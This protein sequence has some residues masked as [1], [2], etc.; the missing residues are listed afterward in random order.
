MLARQTANAFSKLRSNARFCP[1]VWT[2]MSSS[3]A[4]V[5]PIESNGSKR[6]HEGGYRF[7]NKKQK[8]AAK[9]VKEG[10]NEEVLLSDVRALLE[11]FSLGKS[12]TNDSRDDGTSLHE[13]PL[14]EQFSEIELTIS[15]LSSTGDGLAFDQDS[16]RAYV[17]PFTAPGDV[18][19]AKVVKHFSEE[20]YSLTDFV[21]VM[22]A[23][24]RR[25]DSRIRCP[26]FARCSGCQFQM[27][28]Y[29]DQLLHKKTIVEKAYRRFSGL[30]P[31]LVPAVGKTMGS[32]LQYGYRTKLTPHFD[33]PPGE[34]RDRRHGIRAK[35]QEVP[36]I[37]FMQKGTRKTIDIEDC[38]IGTDAVRMGMKRERKR[39]SEEIDS[40]AR[41]ATILLRES[42]K[43]VGKPGENGNAVKTDDEEP[44]DVIREDHDDY[45]HEKTCITDNN[46]TSTEYVE[47]F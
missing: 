10:S 33:G 27:L 16:K 44:K 24:P 28:S 11:K 5:A 31:R 21:K 22:Q 25:D 32:P 41:G 35:F 2:K 19:T 37:G 6:R 18:V 47:D 43:R 17:V 38:P 30:E 3:A 8:K 34:R 13:K 9:P 29:E 7:K 46:A 40:Y 4:A 1:R 12:D 42:T 14:P 23:S 45:I 36:P 26:Y 39:V 20:A 15:E